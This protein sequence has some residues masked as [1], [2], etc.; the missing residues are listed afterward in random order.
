MISRKAL[1]LSFRSAIFAAALCGSM[2]AAIAQEVDLDACLGDP[3]CD[4]AEFS[5][6]QAP[7]EAAQALDALAGPGGAFPGGA[8]GYV[9]STWREQSATHGRLTLPFAVPRRSLLI[10]S[11]MGMYS[12]KSQGPAS[13][14]Y[15]FLDVDSANCSNAT[16]AYPV[17]GGATFHA[18][19]TC[20]AALEP[21]T[22]EVS[23]WTRNWSSGAFDGVRRLRVR[24]ALIPLN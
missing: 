21:G 12:R 17:G 10:A 9:D 20:L 22:H 13:G 14:I 11:G 15:Y 3:A 18:N 23:F 7:A 2:P 8:Y 16:V 19:V 1:Y 6:M 24:Y 5:S 4:P